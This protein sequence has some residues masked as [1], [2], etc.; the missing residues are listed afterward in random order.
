MCR[1]RRSP[2]PPASARDLLRD[3]GLRDRAHLRT[4]SSASGFARRSSRAGSAR[5]FRTTSRRVLLRRLTEVEGMERYLR[6][7]FLGQKQFSIEGLDVMVPMLDEAIELAARGRRARRRDRHGPPRPAER[8]RSHRRPPVRRRSCAS[9][10]ARR[11][12]RRSTSTRRAAPATSSTTTAP[13]ACARPRAATSAS[14]L[15]S[16]P[17]HLEYVDPVVEGETRALQTDHESRERTHDPTRRA[18]R[19]DP[20][21]RGLP[22][23]GRRRGDAQPAGAPRLLDRRHAPP[24]R[25]QPDRLHDRS[26]GRALD[27]LLERPRQ[28]LRRLRSST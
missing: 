21:R 27:A 12:S 1:A 28:G 15:A 4:T 10:R 23:P 9:S 17:S 13:R 8:P 6:R 11:R 3:D 25:Q 24:H 2:T 22:G 26:G 20:R 18:R 16:N 5:R 19:P 7:A 14:R